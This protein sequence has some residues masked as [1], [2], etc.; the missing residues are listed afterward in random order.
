LPYSAERLAIGTQ[1]QL[2]VAVHREL[3]T[4]RSRSGQS[5]EDEHGIGWRGRGDHD[6]VAVCA[7]IESIDIADQLWWHD[8]IDTAPED[9]LLPQRAIGV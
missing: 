4:L 2:A 9:P 8:M 6:D 5:F 3:P 1:H 7:G